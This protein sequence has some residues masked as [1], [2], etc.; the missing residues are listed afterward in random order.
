M[1]V[2]GPLIVASVVGIQLATALQESDLARFTKQIAAGIRQDKFD[3]ASAFTVGEARPVL[4][5]M[6]SSSYRVRAT[7]T[8]HEWISANLYNE[9][10]D[11]S[12]DVTIQSSLGTNFCISQSDGS[13]SAQFTYTD[14]IVYLNFY[15]DDSCST[16]AVAQAQWLN[17]SGVAENECTTSGATSSGKYS[18]DSSYSSPNQDGYLFRLFSSD[19]YCDNNQ[20]FMSLFTETAQY[21]ETDASCASTT[22]DD[23]VYGANLNVY[24]SYGAVSG[25]TSSKK[26]CFAAS[27]TLQLATGEAIPISDV[28]IGDIVLAADKMGNTKFS[29]V[30]ALPHDKNNERAVF[31][32]ITTMAGRGIKVTPD[33]IML[34]DPSCGTAKSVLMKASEVEK[35]MCLS[36]VDGLDQVTAVSSVVGNGIYTVITNEEM[37]VVNGIIASPF[38]VNH[39]VSHAYYNIFRTLNSFAPGLMDWSLLKQT[40]LAFGSILD[41]MGM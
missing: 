17:T 23:D 2:L 28:N 41:S 26:K 38:A 6:R 12:G 40:N 37:V 25:S 31:A 4:G 10:S 5:D 35:N 3:A 32:Y 16:T 29:Q 9:S 13:G 39:A 36:T 21:G 30:I 33:H 15:S 11:C 7:T 19:D 24:M 34:V 1:H 14:N 20:P 18:V 8:S 22:V 27:E